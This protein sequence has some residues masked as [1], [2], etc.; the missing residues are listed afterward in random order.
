VGSLLLNVLPYAL[1]AAAAAPAVAVV[2]A[3]ILARSE[4]PIVSAW[5][6]TAG[7]A[8]LDVVFSVAALAALEGANAQGNGDVGAL[9]DCVLGALFL[10]LAVMAIF[11]KETPEKEAARRAR[12]ES[13]ASGGIRTML[14]AGVVA[15]VINFD[16]IAMFAGGLKEVAEASVSDAEAAVAVAIALV[17]MLIPYY[18]PAVVYAASPERSSGPLRSL[19]DWLLRNS[20]M[21]EIVVGLGFGA[22]FLWKGIS[23]LS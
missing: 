13:V 4:R 7:A 3:L 12:A 6:F 10:G 19:S 22:A 14:I 20:R 23:G 8:S 18:G 1:A 16:A 15:Q 17:V 5:A 9:V 11:S 21:L 2:T